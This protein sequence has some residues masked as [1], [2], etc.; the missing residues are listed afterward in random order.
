MCFNE[1]Q[2]IGNGLVFPSGPLRENLSSLK[3]ADVILING[4]KNINFEKKI[5]KINKNLEIF[6]S[7][8]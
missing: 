7:S 1:N 6:Y 2:L 8:L 4:K 5:L 3:N